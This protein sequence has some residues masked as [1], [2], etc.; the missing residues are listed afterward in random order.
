LELFSLKDTFDALQI[1][2]SASKTKIKS[3]VKRDKKECKVTSSTENNTL[4]KTNAGT[5]D[6]IVIDQK[7]EEISNCTSESNAEQQR[8]EIDA[9]TA[10]FTDDDI[11]VMDPLFLVI[12]DIFLHLCLFSWSVWKRI[13]YR[14]CDTLSS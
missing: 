12:I 9:I 13:E 7:I 10:I 14:F 4:F 2:S 3:D 1:T 5:K 8:D 11:K 6:V